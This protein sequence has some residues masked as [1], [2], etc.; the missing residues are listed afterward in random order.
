MA[1]V[2]WTD[3][4]RV[5]EGNNRGELIYGSNNEFV[6]ET[7]Y[8]YGG[9]DEVHGRRGGEAI[10]GGSGD[11]QLFGHTGND[12]IYGGAGIDYMRA[13]SGNDRLWGHAGDDFITGDAGNDTLF[14]QGGADT[15]NGGEGNDVLFTGGDDL[16]YFELG[17]DISIGRDRVVGGPDALQIDFSGYIDDELVFASGTEILNSDG[18]TGLADDDEFVTATDDGLVLDVAGAYNAYFD[19]DVNLNN[20]ITWD[21]L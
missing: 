20:V 18:R 4:G 13:G 2:Y 1:R 6:V 14:G 10:D 7:I 9:N 15:M 8:S 16:L 5:V 19:N 11:D 21:F 12:R 3:Y 17:P